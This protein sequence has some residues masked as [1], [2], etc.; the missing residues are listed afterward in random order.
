MNGEEPLAPDAQGR[1]LIRWRRRRDR[2]DDVHELLRRI[3]TALIVRD[4]GTA[5]SAEAYEGLRRQV[6]AAA[7]DRRKHLVQLT[8]FAEA[9]RRGDDHEALRSRVEEWLMQANIAVVT[10]PAVEGAFEIVGEGT[11]GIHV[12][13]PAYIDG[14]TGTL[15][16]KGLGELTLPAVETEVSQTSGESSQ[17]HENQAQE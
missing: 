17:S 3:D 10:D 9:V 8:E 11:G 2:L 14:A 4:P 16:R 7:S 13:Q 12:H 6:V 1:G 15:I 5:R